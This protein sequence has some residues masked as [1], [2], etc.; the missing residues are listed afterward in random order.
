MNLT[1][2]QQEKCDKLLEIFGINN[3]IKKCEEE[4]GELKFSLFLNSTRE[5]EKMDI[6][7]IAQESADVLITLY[8]M[9]EGLGIKDLV[10]SFVDYKLKRTFE[11]VESG[12]Y[13]T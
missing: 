5:P 3:Q 4:L 12:Y 2:G 11:R 13:D 6:P 10:S 8:Q 1:A 9:I 7:N